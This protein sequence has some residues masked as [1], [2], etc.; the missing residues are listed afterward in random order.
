M[1]DKKEPSAADQNDQKLDSIAHMP[2]ETRRRFLKRGIL[3]GALLFAGGA[4]G[5]GLRGTRL[6][7]LPAQ[8]LHLLDA[9]EY[10]ILAAVAARIVPGDSVGPDWPTA[11]AMDCAGKIDALM[12]RLHPE[13]GAEFRQL[14]RLFEN[15]LLGLVTN[16]QPAPFTSLSH[17]D[18]DARLQSWSTSK[19]ALLRSGYSAITRLVYATY[20]SSPEVYPLVG[21]S[22]PPEVAR[23]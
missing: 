20:Y 7:R 22:G 9:T 6:T 11:M 23:P 1:N 17:Q 13:T 8:S 15:G 19:I 2:E 12:A 16:L 3:G 10:T 5:I 4:L 18:Q 14:L 21:Y